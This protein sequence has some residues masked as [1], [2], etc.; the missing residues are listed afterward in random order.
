MCDPLTIAGIA[1][2]A[3]STVAN[4]IGAN[5]ARAARDDALAAERIRQRGFDQ[6]SQ[7]LNAESQDRYLDFEGQREGKATELGEFFADQRIETADANQAATEGTVLPPSSSNLTI[8]EEGKQ[9]GTARAFADQQGEALGELRSFG[10]LLSDIG[11]DQ[12]RDASLISQIGGFK[13]G[14]SG[15]LPLE[16]EEASQAG[17]KFKLFGDILGLG[18]SI[19]VGKGLSGGKVTTSGFVDPWANLRRPTGAASLYGVS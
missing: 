4:T 14:S 2:T 17:N 6:E 1:L 13:R 3:G 10:D 8:R 12:A 7:A 19:A 16:L 5:R 9:R 11:R 18:G 15:V